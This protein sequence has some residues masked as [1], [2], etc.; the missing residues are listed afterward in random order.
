L[1]FL[2]GPDYEKFLD[3]I[4]PERQNFFAR[5][6]LRQEL[7]NTIGDLTAEIRYLTTEE[8]KEIK[9]KDLFYKPET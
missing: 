9:K 2:S 6:R 8:I 1:Y 3:A 5:P 4:G 7:Q